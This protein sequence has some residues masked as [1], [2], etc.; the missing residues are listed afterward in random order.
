LEAPAIVRA[1]VGDRDPVDDL[2]RHLWARHG[3]LYGV[4]PA[5]RDLSPATSARMA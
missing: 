2:L 3:E 4:A 1:A 5:S